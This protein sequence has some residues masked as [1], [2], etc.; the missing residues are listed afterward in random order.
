[1]IT[2]RGQESH[3]TTTIAPRLV[4]GDGPILFH[5][6][7]LWSTSCKAWILQ[8]WH[9]LLISLLLIITNLKLFEFT[10][11]KKTF[12]NNEYVVEAFKQFIS[13]KAD[14]FFED[15]IYAS[16]EWW[17]KVIN[18]KESIFWLNTLKLE[19]TVLF[20]LSN[21]TFHASQPN[22]RSVLAFASH[23]SIL[24]FLR[25]HHITEQSTLLKVFSRS[26]STMIHP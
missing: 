14:K 13:V 12:L 9:I 6:L 2:A 25:D 22:I 7:K 23:S 15:G 26:T 10:I 24:S 8:F 21:A 4:N 16:E 11:H 1:M 5:I 3:Q 19:K 18:E 20:P 17:M